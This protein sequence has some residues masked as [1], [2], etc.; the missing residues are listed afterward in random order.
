MPLFNYF[1]FYR[2]GIA[3]KKTEAKENEENKKGE[4]LSDVAAMALARRVAVEFPIHNTIVITKHYVMIF[5]SF[6]ET[7]L[8]LNLTMHNLLL[9]L[10]PWL[11]QQNRIK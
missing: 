7:N 3:L 6:V 1:P 4:S 2:D 5:L 10:Q 11:T 9:L 8:N